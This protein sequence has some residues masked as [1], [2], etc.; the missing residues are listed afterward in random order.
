MEFF[1]ESHPV[2]NSQNLA[3]QL[4]LYYDDIE[5][6][7]PLGSRAGHHKLGNSLKLPCKMYSSL[8]A[9]HDKFHCIFDIFS[10]LYSHFI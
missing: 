2:F 5:T 7:N 8:H 3:L 9:F 1:F 4:I 10:D 6:G